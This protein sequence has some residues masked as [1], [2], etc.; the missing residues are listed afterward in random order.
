MQVDK[1]P[2]TDRTAW[3]ANRQK[4]VTASV[5]GALFGEH[6]YCTPLSLYLEKSSDEPPAEYDDAVLRRG[7]VFESAVAVAASID[8]KLGLVPMGSTYFRAP[9]VRIGATPDYL[10][11]SAP[12]DMQHVMGWPFQIKTVDP[13]VFDRDWTQEEAP[14]WVTLQ[15][16]T[17]AMLLDTT[18]ALIGAMVMKA[19]FPVHYYP[20]PRNPGAEKRIIKGVEDFWKSVAAKEM[21]TPDYH[22]DG[23]LLKELYKGGGE[24]VDLT[25]NNRIAL[26]CEE[27]IAWARRA[28]NCSHALE[29][30]DAEIFDLLRN[31]ER[32]DHP[33][34]NITAKV[35]KKKAFTVAATEF[36]QLRVTRKH[37]KPEEE[38]A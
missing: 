3:M 8:K 15:A 9:E 23:A 21:P 12:D 36:R 10:V 26:L 19:P 32:A 2:Y 25:Q 35:T 6:P 5:V 7:R 34:F 20:V 30:I 16:L 33:D 27:K 17:E 11:D 18:G 24:T 4:D 13:R 38:A 37:A 22:R 31:A 29:T 14:L 28:T 1:I